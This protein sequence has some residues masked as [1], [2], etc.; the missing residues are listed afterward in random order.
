[1][2]RLYSFRVRGVLL[3]FAVLSS[4]VQAQI[5]KCTEANGRSTYTDR[6]CMSAAEVIQTKPS[7]GGQSQRRPS[8]QIRPTS[9]TPAQVNKVEI[10]RLSQR[11]G[12]LT[13]VL[14]E[15][16]MMLA[17]QSIGGSA[18]A[19][20]RIRSYENEL[21]SVQAQKLALMGYGS[22]AGVSDDRIRDLENRLENAERASRRPIVENFTMNG[23]HCQRA[24][25][26]VTC[27]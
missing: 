4:Q 8:Y 11:E 24:A 3:F 21:R 25:G 14:D 6:P 13:R 7:T 15:E 19:R 2:G 18:A 16:R 23:R 5:Y 20:T 22:S 12:D 10:E 27:F 1:M 26:T 17:S 9:E